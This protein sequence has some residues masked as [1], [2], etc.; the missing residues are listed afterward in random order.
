M[1][2]ASPFLGP[3]QPFSFRFI[4]QPLLA[5]LLGLRDG[6]RDATDGKPPYAFSLLTNRLDRR[7]LAKEGLRTV[8]LPLM[9]AIVLDG[10]VQLLL[11]HRVVVWRAVVVGVLLIGLPYI[12]SRGLTN[13][14]VGRRKAHA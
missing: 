2:L 13:R 10:V 8:A 6:K 5:I 12:A 9:V 1:D 7:V 14:T 11:R 3:D 4:V